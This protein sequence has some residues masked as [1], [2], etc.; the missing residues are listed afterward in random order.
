MI[1]QSCKP[2][3]TSVNSSLR[4]TLAFTT[5]PSNM[6]EA[7]ITAG[8][9]V[10]IRDASIPKPEHGWVLI[11]VIY[12][13]SNPKDWKVPEWMPDPTPRNQGND[14]AGFVEAVGEGV[15]EFRVGDRV[16]AF[17][18]MEGGGYAE[19]AVARAHTTF[20]LPENVSFQGQ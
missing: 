8:P 10:I 13:G 19:Y 4:H 3:F 1:L 14:V 9:K 5:D 2:V 17:L 18:N 7:V 12:A 11:K 15:T 6:K 16:A 20:F